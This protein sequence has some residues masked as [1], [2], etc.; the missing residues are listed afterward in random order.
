MVYNA[1]QTPVYFEHIPTRTVETKGDR[2]VWLRSAG[3]AKE[4]VKC[5][6]LGDFLGHEDRRVNTKGDRG[7]EKLGATRVRRAPLGSS[8][9][10]SACTRAWWNTDLSSRFLDYHFG[11]RRGLDVPPVLLLWDDFPAHW[12]P[13]VLARAL[14]LRVELMCFPVGYT[15]ACQPADVS[16]NAPL[17]QRLRM[18]W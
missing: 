6:L 1:D 17:R 4:R 5:M 10:A 15:S 18:H 16:W 14:E 3:K 7:R 8:V 12:S 9:P 2:T 13:P 11:D